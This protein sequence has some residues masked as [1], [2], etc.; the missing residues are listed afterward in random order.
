VPRNRQDLGTWGIKSYQGLGW[1][2]SHEIFE[3]SEMKFRRIG[4]LS[5]PPFFS[6]RPWHNHFISIS[7][8]CPAVSRMRRLQ[9]PD[10]KRFRPDLSSRSP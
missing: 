9:V 5:V 4:R 8:M 7:I 3:T 2:C 10:V 6:L 1:G